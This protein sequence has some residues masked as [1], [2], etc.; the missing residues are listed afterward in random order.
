[1]SNVKNIIDTLKNQGANPDLSQINLIEKLCKM[2]IS[3]KSSFKKIFT[4]DIL[5]GTYIWGDVGRG[6]TLITKT[7]LKE[8]KRDDIKSFHYIDLMRFIHK[9]LNKNS[10]VKNPLSKVSKTLTKDTSIIFIDEFQVE[11][12]ADAMIIGD[13]LKLISEQGT[14]IILTSNAHPDDLY[15]DGLQRHKFLASLKIFLEN[16]NIHK[17]DGKIDYRTRN[18]IKFDNH[19]SNKII[20]DKEIFKF[21]VD[22]FALDQQKS[23]QVLINDRKFS[24]KL[25]AN[26]ILWIEFS[27]FF[28][29]A[30]GPIDY[31]YI[32]KKFDWV[33]ISNFKKNDDDTIDII[34]RFIS[35]IDITYTHK[36][37]IKFFFDDIAIESI[38]TGSKIGN[39]WVR[40]KSR[41]FEM[42]TQEYLTHN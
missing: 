37:K 26:N 6:K 30:T 29:E 1:M 21:I 14:K 22:N 15:V 3:K 34:R 36:T 12:V 7:Y 5:R 33:F 17:L 16:I 25:V 24:C 38:Y 27:N 23:D 41:L 28:K 20:S 2:N 39:L 9:H 8:L 19:D 31:T 35:F 10:G 13:L 42:R 18:I 11:D 32:S 40:C 4:K